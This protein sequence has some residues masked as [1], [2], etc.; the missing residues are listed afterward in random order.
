MRSSSR[1]DSSSNGSTR[2]GS[3]SRI[4]SKTDKYKHRSRSRS[5]DSGK[6][7]KT[8]TYRQDNR[9][10]E[11][12]SRSQERDRG[13]RDYK[14]KYDRE[15]NVDNRRNDRSSDNEHRKS[16]RRYEDHKQN[17]RRNDKP[18]SKNIERWPNDMYLESNAGPSNSGGSHRSGEKRVNVFSN[19]NKKFHE[20]ELLD[21]RRLQREAIG[22]EGVAHVWG[23]SPQRPNE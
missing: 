9:R 1:S 11:R 3:K 18:H 10:S 7:K 14:S 16:T 20:E 12:V 2:R 6:G 4:A 15:S 17:D 23:K 13:R 22:I 21:T 5:N 19:A 8:S